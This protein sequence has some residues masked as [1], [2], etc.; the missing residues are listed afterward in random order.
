MIHHILG[1]ISIVWDKDKHSS[2]A[3]KH[4]TH[5]KTTS[6][7]NKEVIALTS[8]FGT[9]NA[10]CPNDRYIGN[11]TPVVWWHSRQHIEPFPQMDSRRTTPEIK[12][13][14]S[15]GVRNYIRCIPFYNTIWV[16]AMFD[17]E[18]YNGKKDDMHKTTSKDTHQHILSTNKSRMPA[19]GND[20]TRTQ[21]SYRR[22]T[23]TVSNFDDTQIIDKMT[24]SYRT[25]PHTN[26][27]KTKIAATAHDKPKKSSST[28]NTTNGQCKSNCCEL[29]HDT[30]REMIC[31]YIT[32][33]YKTKYGLEIQQPHTPDIAVQTSSGANM[34]MNHT[35]SG[36]YEG[37]SINKNGVNIKSGGGN[38][39]K[40]PSTATA[41]K[42]RWYITPKPTSEEYF[43]VIKLSNLIIIPWKNRQRPTP[44]VAAGLLTITRMMTAM[45][46]GTHSN[47]MWTSICSSSKTRNSLWNHGM[48][49]M[50]MMWKN[51]W[52]SWT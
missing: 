22:N 36:N 15:L 11:K 33:L 10:S 44:T 20:E 49:R 5:T 50:H 43:C 51:R 41:P 46:S 37:A 8:A 4:V 45:T 26:P 6:G 19:R 13:E 9:I 31:T 25:N 1:I 47:A 23:P 16:R 7:R 14:H 12:K 39:K 21:A 48:K 52:K 27:D 38:T 18:D 40:K 3:T 32:L 34:N 30:N 2:L 35:K 28:P 42:T 17:K 24:K 29:I